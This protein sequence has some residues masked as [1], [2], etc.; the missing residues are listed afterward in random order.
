MENPELYALYESLEEQLSWSRLN[1]SFI[2]NDEVGAR[3]HW[4]LVKDTIDLII[5]KS[6]GTAPLTQPPMGASDDA[7]YLF[8]QITGAAYHGFAFRQCL[9]HN[10]DVIRACRVLV[11]ALKDAGVQGMD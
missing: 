2:R 3:V 5:E 4:K 7:R 11:K 8:D 6:G 1:D 9:A 10:P